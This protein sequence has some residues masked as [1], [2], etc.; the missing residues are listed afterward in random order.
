LLTNSSSV[1]TPASWSS[2]SFARADAAPLPP[3]L[4]NVSGVRRCAHV[5][6]PAMA[7]A[8][9]ADAV[10]YGVSQREVPLEAAE[11]RVMSMHASKGLTADLVVLAGLVQGIVPRTDERLSEAEQEAQ[12]EE[13]RRLFFVAMTRTTNI[14][15]FSSYSRLDAA[16]AHRLQTDRARGCQAATSVFSLAASSA[17]WASSVLRRYAARTGCTSDGQPRDL[18]PGYREP[19]TQAAETLE[20]T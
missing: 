14:L 16:T 17:N 12:F 10:R 7:S 9:P 2:A 8:T 11:V 3:A 20:S 15:V 5:C 18:W 4:P 6:T 19:N 13:Q 1:T